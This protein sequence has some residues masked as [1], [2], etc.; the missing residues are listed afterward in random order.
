VTDVTIED[1]AGWEADLAALTGGL[2]KLFARPGPRKTFADMVGGLLADV[3][4][5]NSW[6]LAER[7][8]HRSA[9]GLEWLLGGARWDA[10]VLRDQVRSYVVQG[11]GGN[12]GELA[13]LVIDDTQVIK[14]GNKSVGV[15][16]QH[17]GLTGQIENC[18]V[19]VMM[20]YATPAG[21]AFVDRELYLPERWTSD[22]ARLAQ[23]GGARGP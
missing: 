5:K 7:A 6:Q 23:A 1:V 8:G 13:A 18:Q 20:T 12:A 2:G 19:L 9:Y 4:R 16:P 21:H 11:L 22:P 3:P 14:Q 17:C 10:D 15:A